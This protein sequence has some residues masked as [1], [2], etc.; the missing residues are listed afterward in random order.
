MRKRVWLHTSDKY[1]GAKKFDI[2]E[3]F[4]L[5]DKP[6]RGSAQFSPISS[7]FGIYQ[8]IMKT[9][10]HYKDRKYRSTTVER[11]T[12]SKLQEKTS[13]LK[14]MST[15]GGL[16]RQRSSRAGSFTTAVAPMERKTRRKSAIMGT[17][18]IRTQASA[19][20][21]LKQTPEKNLPSA[22]RRASQLLARDSNA[23]DRKDP[24]GS[25]IARHGLS[26][27][28]DENGRTYPKDR[29]QSRKQKRPRD[30]RVLE[31]VHKICMRRCKPLSRESWSHTRRSG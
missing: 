26:N 18:P 27:R 7:S 25:Q 10:D 1:V 15:S 3:N 14:N 4:H 23:G 2:T 12:S 31:K 20:A 8:V 29:R 16:R 5:I 22:H 13:N 21:S 28:A 17:K 11:F 19:S 24:F 30:H 9:K 6:E